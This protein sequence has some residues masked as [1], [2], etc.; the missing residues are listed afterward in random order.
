VVERLSVFL[1]YPGDDGAYV[2]IDGGAGRRQV[3]RDG[4][5]WRWADARVFGAG[6]Y[7]HG[8]PGKPEKSCENL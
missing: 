1:S 4:G 2:C 6:K 8:P 3:K 5:R 7:V